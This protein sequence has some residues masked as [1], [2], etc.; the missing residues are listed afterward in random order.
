MPQTAISKPF[1]GGV[2]IM[3]LSGSKTVS[4]VILLLVTGML[5]ACI[6][7]ASTL[8]APVQKAGDTTDMAPSSLLPGL[9]DASVSYT[10]TV[11]ASP[12]AER[13]SGVVLESPVAPATALNARVASGELVAEVRESVQPD[14]DGCTPEP[15]SIVLTT[16]GLL[17][18]I[19]ARRFR[20]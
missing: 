13:G 16:S 3:T 12:A 14:H 8:S 7:P 11:S 19:G 10:D 18:L 1:T 17:G 4:R 15:V 5:G 6:S 9:M 2:K 20:K